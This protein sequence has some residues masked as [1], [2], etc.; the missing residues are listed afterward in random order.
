MN[1]LD[2]L[3]SSIGNVE[4]FTKLFKSF[5]TDENSELFKGK[6]LNNRVKYL[7]ECVLPSGSKITLKFCNVTKKI[8]NSKNVELP[9]RE[10]WLSYIEIY[11]TPFGKKAYSISTDIFQFTWA[12]EGKI[13]ATELHNKKIDQLKYYAS[14]LNIDL[15]EDK[16]RSE[17]RRVGKEC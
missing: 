9:G 15:S 11:V 3:E 6:F 7:H 14:K 16:F 2:Q 1:Y 4:E 10:S 8:R 17:E 13:K 5:F 12:K